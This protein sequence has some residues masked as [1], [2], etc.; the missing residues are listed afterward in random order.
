MNVH[1][2]RSILRIRALVLALA[3]AAAAGVHARAGSQEPSHSYVPR[4]GFVPDA[5]T[6]TRIAEAVLIPIYA[7]RQIQA[8]QPLSATLRGDAWLVTG[9]LPAGSAGGVAVVEIAKRDARVLR[10][11]HGR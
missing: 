8:Q 10:V 4:E 3:V 7:A 11:S 1:P 5:A 9:Q 2:R 6:A